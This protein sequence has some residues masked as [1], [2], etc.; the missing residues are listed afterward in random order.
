M[1]VEAERFFSEH[2]IDAEPRQGKPAGAFCAWPSTR[3]PGFVL[4]NWNGRVGDVLTSRT[5]S[6]TGC[7]LR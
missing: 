4:V 3:T 5:S 6:G 7:T 1:G 2:R